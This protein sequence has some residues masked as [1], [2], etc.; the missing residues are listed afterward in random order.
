[1]D[2]STNANHP[3]PTTQPPKHPLQFLGPVA[4]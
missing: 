1:M 4:N 3:S 2:V